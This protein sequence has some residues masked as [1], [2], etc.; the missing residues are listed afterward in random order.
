MTS[1]KI[2][3]AWR[4]NLYQMMIVPLRRWQMMI[5]PTMKNR[6]LELPLSQVGAGGKYNPQ[7]NPGHNELPA[8][9]DLVI[10]DMTVRD[11]IGLDNYKTRLQPNNGRDA[12]W[13]A[14][15]EALDLAVYLR[16]AIFERD[17]K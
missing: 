2:K 17:N 11:Q 9:W 8:V 3:P 16:Q 15:E 12:L 4:L 1:Q 7:P 6:Q 13:D 5:V 14:Y 10:K